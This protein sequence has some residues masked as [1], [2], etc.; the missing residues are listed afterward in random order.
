MRAVS[1]RA[2]FWALRELSILFIGFVSLFA[3]DVFQEAHGFWQVLV[4]LT[5]HLIFEK[6]VE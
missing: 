1:S 2:L 6:G 3:L 4:G 5:M